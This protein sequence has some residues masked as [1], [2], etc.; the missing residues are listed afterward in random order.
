[1]NAVSGNGSPLSQ[2][3][4]SQMLLVYSTPSSAGIPD[5]QNMP[6]SQ[7]EPTYQDQVLIQLS[8]PW[9]ASGWSVTQDTYTGPPPP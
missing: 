2:W 6:R 3:F 5:C 1:M 9:A 8:P 4:I 7:P